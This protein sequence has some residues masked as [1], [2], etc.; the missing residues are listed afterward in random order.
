VPPPAGAMYTLMQMNL[1]LSGLA[2]CY[3]RVDYPA[4]V[5]E[6]M[7]RIRETHPDAVTFNEACSNNVA[8]IARRTAYRVCFSRVIYDLKPLACIHP[9]SYGLFGDAVLTKAAI[10]GTESRAFE[11]RAGPARRVWLWS[12]PASVST[13]APPC[14]GPHTPTTTSCSSAHLTAQ[15]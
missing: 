12:A 10:D 5:Q 15:H 6:A 7:V 2:S 13:C 3:S 11:A 9:S 1:C 4:G 14:C 8:Q